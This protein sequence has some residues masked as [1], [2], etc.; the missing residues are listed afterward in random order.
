MHNIHLFTMTY[1]NLNYTWLLLPRDPKIFWR[2]T[3][4]S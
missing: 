3:W 2:L 4:R 1:C